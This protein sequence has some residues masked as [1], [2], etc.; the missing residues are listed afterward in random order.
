[1]NMNAMWKATAVLLLIAVA[2]GA[3]AA[4]P[5]KTLRITFQVAETGF[6]P[7]LIHDYYSGTVIEAVYDT[8]LTYDYLARP[9]RLAPRAAELPEVTDGGRTYTFKLKK[10]ILFTPDA[11]FKGKRRE[12]V[13]EDF[14]YTIKRFLDPKNRSPYAFFFEGKIL[15]LDALA[16]EAKESGKFDYDK[17]IPG[18]E[19][20]NPYT[21]RIKL[22]DPDFTFS[23]ILAFA[24]TSAVAREV[25]EAYGNESNF[26]P[27][28]TGPYMLDKYVRSSKIFLK[29]NPDFR[30]EFWD[31]KP[32]NDP[33][34][35]DIVARMKGKQIPA[36]G[37]VEIS[38]VEETQARMLAFENGETDLE[39]QLW[40]VS[41]RFLTDDNK[42][43]PAFANKGVRL[44]RIVDAEITY[45][46][47][48]TMDKIGN[49]P[50]PVGGFSRERIALRRAIAM[51]YNLSDQIKIIR[52]NQAVK[53]EYPI[54]PGVSGNEPTWKN[55]INYDP[56]GANSL[57]DRVG[58]KKAADGFR[59][60]PDGS[61]LVIRYSTTPDERG[62]LF[63]E[64][65]KKSMDTIGVRVDIHIDKF[66]ELLKAEKQC[67]IM[68]RGSAW[69]ADYPDGDNFMQLLYGQNAF[70]SNNACYQSAEYDKLYVKSKLMPDSPERNKLYREMTKIMERDT[71][72][73]MND[74]RYRNTLLQPQVVGFKKHP[75]LH[76]D[77]IY[78]DLEK[79][80]K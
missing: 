69:I 18:F 38:I 10:G 9:S 7:A 27:V 59:N 67:R 73:I 74:S 51:A 62:R 45:T 76:A 56:A 53:A 3:R 13:A 65:I 37:N 52:K 80:T 50:N 39:Y 35:K 49:Q 79:R 12:L 70:Q 42:L 61:P 43:V 6:D 36:I 32:G 29:A 2:L 5:N 40:D 1:M 71:P 16:A 17:K 64:L 8:L 30:K 31:F 19:F 4:D 63:A 11:A 55:N 20:P 77:W 60:Q 54:P 46:Y 28:G 44:D 72:W 26:H 23:Q 68:M 14:A 25:I 66:P 47:F 78:I 21:L 22:K 24:E 34:D 41:T 48:N 15:G 33:R 75:I 57:L 58:Y